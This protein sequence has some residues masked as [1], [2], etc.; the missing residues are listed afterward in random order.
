MEAYKDKH[1]KLVN[2]EPCINIIR[3]INS[4]IR[5][6]NSR[7]PFE[8]LKLNSP[9][10]NVIPTFNLYFILISF[11]VYNTCVKCMLTFIC[12]VSGYQGVSRIH[13]RLGKLHKRKGF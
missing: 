6:M 7:T 10:E 11:S 9:E 8:A 1:P 13:R 4:G 2:S 5:A 3:L 12:N